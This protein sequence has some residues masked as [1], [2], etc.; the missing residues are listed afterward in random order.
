MQLARELKNL[1][2]TIYF[3]TQGVDTKDESAFVV[4]SILAALAEEEIRTISRN[5]KWGIQKRYKD[6][7]VHMGGRMYGYTIK[8]GKFTVV[9]HEA[10]IVQQM[11]AD[12]LG[13]MT[14]RQIVNKLEEKGVPTAYAE[15]RR[16]KM[17]EKG[18]TEY[19]E[20]RWQHGTVLKLLENEKYMGD[21]ILQKT[22]KV[23][24]LSERQ[25]NVGQRDKYE[26][27]NNHT[28]II[29]RDTYHAVQAEIR[30]REY[31][32]IS[33]ATER[34]RYSSKY[35]L[36]TKLECAECGTKFRRHSQTHG[37]KKV[38]I[39]VCINHQQ[40]K[41]KCAMKPIK[42]TVAQEIFVGLL[43][44]ISANK[45][46][47]LAKAE[48]LVREVI[49]KNPVKNTQEL[50]KALT[51]VEKQLIEV[52]K[53]SPQTD[54]DKEQTRQLMAKAKQLREEIAIAERMKGVHEMLKQRLKELRQIVRT[55]YTE[56]NDDVFR[57]L[58]EKVI[59]VDKMTLRFVLKCG[60]DIPYQLQPA[61]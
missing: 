8:E 17:K 42:E 52:G 33:L 51:A 50:E 55:A 35:A 40:D 24:V 43:G 15:I 10:V 38:D 3:E 22:F 14:I 7:K 36:S 12:Y 61:A 9:P 5:V 37:D 56:F 58:I 60:V 59:V 53:R 2:V 21:V 39:W 48:M 47:I 34:T 16:K 13:G 44:Y 46:K 23:D 26:V 41:S 28:A 49:E 27:L 25:K 30:K 45:D 29:D 57:C 54:A 11:F 18:V 19:K 6:G 31:E 32:K 20:T 4:L 1:G